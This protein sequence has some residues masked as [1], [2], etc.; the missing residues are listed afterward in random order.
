MKVAPA[1]ASGQPG[2]GSKKPSDY[3]CQLHYKHARVVEPESTTDDG[4]KRLK[5]VGDKGT[6]ITAAELGLVDKYRDLKRAGQDILT[7]DWP[8]HY[9]SILYACY[10]NQYKI[11]QMV[12]REFVGSTQE[13][14]AMHTTRCWVGKNSAM[15]AAYQGHLET[16]LYIIDLDMQG[17]FTEDL[18]KQ[19]D[20]MGKNAMMWAASQGHTDTIEVLLVRSLYRLL[21]EDCADPLVL[22]TRWKLVSLLADLASHCRDYDPGCSRS[23]FQEVLASIKYDPVEGARQEEAAAAGGGGSAREG[24][25]LH[26]PTWGVDDGEEEERRHG[27]KHSDLVGKSAAST[28]AAAAAGGKTASGKPGEPGGGGAV[29]L[30]DVHITVR[31]LQ[32][33][34]V[35]AYRAGM[36]C[37]GVIMYCQSLLQ[38]A[39]YFDD[40]VAQ[41]TAWEV[42]LLDTCRNKQEVQAILAP[43]ED[44]PSEPVG[45]ALATFDKA[46][47]SH[48]FVQQIFTEKWD[49]MGVTDYTKSLFGV[50][51]G[52]CSL[53]VAFAAWA[54]ICPLVVVARSFLSPV[55]DFM[56]RGKVIVDSRF[57]WHVP[58]YRWL[59]TQCA[60]IT[61]TVLLSYLV[62]SFDP[63]DP[64][65]AS[66][67]PL[68]TFLAVWCAAILVDEVQEYV[69]EGR[70]EY[71]SSGW[72]VMDVT[73]ALSY[74][75][76]YI[77]RII[78]VRVTDNLNILLVVN[79]L[80][81]A[82]ALMAW[83]R[84]VSVFELSS[85]IGPLIQMMK[86]MLIKDVTRFALLVLVILLGFS[87]G[88]EALFQEACIE[89]DPTT[90][91]CTKYTSWGYDWQKDGLVGGMTFLQYIALGNANP[92]DFE[93]KRVTGVIFYLIF[94]IV[95]AI[96]L[97]NLF[98]AML[99]DTYTRVSTQAMVEFRY[100]KAKLMASYSRRDFVCPPFNL[101]H[102]VCAA[103]GN[104]LR[105][106]VW[107]PD[108]FT[109]VSMRKN[110]TVPLFSWYF[111]QGEEMRQVVVL[112]R[113][114]VDD[115]LNSN[116]VALFREKLNAE[117][118]NL[119]HEMLK[120]KGKGDGGAL[121]GGG[122]A[123]STTVLATAVSVTAAAGH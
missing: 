52:G 92:V 79:D 71:M 51:W 110:E 33:V 42:K 120:Q 72:N 24:A 114:V 108:G 67:A 76:H 83:F 3:G 15:V 55:Q 56:M 12:E 9:S 4:M 30:K 111:P 109:P 61:F 80:L 88:M 58:L 74:I 40:L 29:K 95:T 116:R 107:G 115:F 32:G 25:A 99:A 31:T 112:Q 17:K 48:K 62:F 60:L 21:P 86:Q 37:M 13:L 39:R 35:S 75:L 101:L 45:Y 64:V 96:L 66:V 47:L 104:G 2:G 38:Q 77:L 7:C 6:L 5:D 118:P 98:I 41:L 73:M 43:T 84:M 93:Q 14:T 44:D 106:L 53:V 59:L 113:R 28:T 27:V 19:R 119:V 8:Y 36:N 46:F 54:T 78:A 100:R 97:L 102:L 49:T 20:V 1:P 81:A 68:N 57:P 121:A 85:A 82:A 10:G 23:F 34:I 65:P 63:S 50:V 122:A 11:L 87:V 26:E 89:R 105:R 94:A 117:L 103:V 70:A 91:E 16:M 69:E 22:K 18:F 123:A 90:N